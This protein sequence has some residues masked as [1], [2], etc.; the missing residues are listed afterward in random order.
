MYNIENI[1]IS[2]LPDLLSNIVGYNVQIDNIRVN[3]NGRGYISFDSNSLLDH[4]GI[5]KP[6]YERFQI[7]S[8]SNGFT[9]EGNQYYWVIVNFSFTYKSGGSNGS[10]ITTV[11]YDFDK[12]SWFTQN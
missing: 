5:M 3:T 12:N 11:L 9:T 2:N 4:T 7:S 6:F 8:F 10:T 1:Q